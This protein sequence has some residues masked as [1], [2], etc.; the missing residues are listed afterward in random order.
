MSKKRAEGFQELEC[1]ICNQVVTKVDKA[2][3][4]ITCSDCV[5][6]ELNGGYS[7]TREEWWAAFKAGRI[8]AQADESL[9]K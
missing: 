7:M 3:E 8:R 4:K 6:R 9:E 1:K 5:Q 2:A